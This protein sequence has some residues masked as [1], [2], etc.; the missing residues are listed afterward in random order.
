MP[1]RCAPDARWSP[2]GNPSTLPSSR[3]APRAARSSERSRRAPRDRGRSGHGTPADQHLADVTREIEV[4]VGKRGELRVEEAT[5][6][7]AALQSID[8]GEAGEEADDRGDRRA[9][10]PAGRQQRAR[11]GG[12]AHLGGDLPGELENLMV[13]QEEPGESQRVDDAELLLEARAGFAPPDPPITH[14]PD[15]PTQSS[16]KASLG[17]GVIDPRVAVAEISDQVEAGAVRRASAV[18]AT[19]SG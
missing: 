19:A 18:S 1:R 4:D 17:V 5:H 12:A 8:V 15:A 6:R 2:E 9:T 7:E 10:S 3:I 14:P 11:R 16:P 13:Q